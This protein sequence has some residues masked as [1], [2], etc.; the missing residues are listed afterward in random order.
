MLYAEHNILLSLHSM[1]DIILNLPFKG[2]ATDPVSNKMYKVSN[3]PTYVQTGPCGGGIKFE[4]V[5]KQYIELCPIPEIKGNI[6]ISFS[7][8]A[9]ETNYNW[10]TIFDNLENNTGMYLFLYLEELRVLFGNGA[11]NSELLTAKFTPL[12]WN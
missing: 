6:S 7:F 1:S 2:N 11:M 5:K 4:R 12:I 8:Y 9:D 10:L 3:G